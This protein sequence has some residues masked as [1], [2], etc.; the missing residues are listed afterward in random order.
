MT[1][2]A[3][4]DSSVLENLSVTWP[5]TFDVSTMQK[6]LFGRRMENIILY[7]MRCNVPMS[8]SLYVYN[9]RVHTYVYTI[10]CICMYFIIVCSSALTV[11]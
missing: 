1:Q 2:A 7:R 3:A 6:L 9:C 4:Q 8:L 5:H 11:V 10:T